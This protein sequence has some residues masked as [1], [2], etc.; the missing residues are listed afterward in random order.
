MWQIIRCNFVDPEG[1]WFDGFNNADSV[2]RSLGDILRDWWKERQEST[3]WIEEF[4]NAPPPEGWPDP[5]ELASGM[6]LGMGGGS[7]LTKVTKF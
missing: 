7:G 1:L 5:K 3:K 6:A 4:L 2:N